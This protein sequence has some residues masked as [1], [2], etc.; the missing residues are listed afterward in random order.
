MNEEEIQEIIVAF[1]KAAGR[2]AEA[3]ADAVQLHGA[4]G[5][6]ISEFLSPFLN[7][8]KDKWG[9]SDENRFRFV[10]EVFR[11]TRKI[12]RIQGARAAAVTC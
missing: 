2:A 11:E 3:G 12:V 5:Y 6:L 4:H 7:R 9:G 10:K 1:G 8:R